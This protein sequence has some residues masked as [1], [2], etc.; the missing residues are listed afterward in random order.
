MFES[1]SHLIAR[2]RPR[3][4]YGVA[5][6]D[7]DG[8]GAYELVVSGFGM[9]NLVLA[10]RSGALVDVADPVLADEERQA[11]G[12]AAADLDG[13]GREELYVLN[14]DT[15]AGPKRFGDRL[16]D[17]VEGEGW[18]DLFDD[19]R[20]VGQQSL[21]A[22]RSVAAIDRRGEGRYG[23][24]VANYGGPLA[25]LELDEDGLLRDA[26]AAAGFT[27]PAGGR[28]LLC[29]P[30]VPTS[31]AAGRMD[32]FAANE[33]SPNFLY[34]SDGRG[35]FVESAEAYGVADPDQHGRGVALVDLNGDGLPDLVCGNWEGPSR[36][37]VQSELGLFGDLAPAALAAPRRVRTVIAADFDN[38]GVEELFF[39]NLGD[40]NLL[41][42]RTGREWAEADAGAAAEAGGLGTGAAVADVDGDGRLELLVAHGEAGMQM[43]S[44]F[45]ARA[46]GNHWV[47]VAPLTA[48]GAP[49]RGALVRVRARHEPDGEERTHLRV[50]DAGSGYLCQ[51]EPVAHVG[52]GPGSPEVLG[53]EILWPGGAVARLAGPALDQ[54]LT[55]AHPGLSPGH[56]VGEAGAAP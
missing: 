47:R 55:V 7:L 41:L 11:I 2:N 31:L 22:G 35:G 40:A 23:F 37:W 1:V 32:V 24:V 5:V 10:W 18:R 19:R 45:R 48:A 29:G 21:M 56:R 15:F 36:L 3:L 34:V 13:D 6:A 28:G 17:W 44:L 43:L 50:I 52:L 9:A 51:M 42:R 49:A 16:F 14:T 27:R 30:L 4:S 20:N 8:D 54:T 38:D 26:A 12:L 39:N 46:E 25:L 53:V 33:N